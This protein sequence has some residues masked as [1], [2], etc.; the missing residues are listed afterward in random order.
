MTAKK[1]IAQTPE[2]DELLGD[3]EAP[4]APEEIKDAQAEPEVLNAPPEAPQEPEQVPAAPARVPDK[5]LKKCDAHATQLYRSG[6]FGFDSAQADRI[7]AAG[8]NPK[9]VLAVATKK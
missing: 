3:E 4:G 1:E 6:A 9:S 7:R 8:Y 5:N 2:L